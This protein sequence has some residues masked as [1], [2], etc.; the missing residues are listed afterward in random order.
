MLLWHIETLVRGNHTDLLMATMCNDGLAY[1]NNHM[2]KIP[3]IDQIDT[4]PCLNEYYN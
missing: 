3:A 2:Y 1:H 4:L